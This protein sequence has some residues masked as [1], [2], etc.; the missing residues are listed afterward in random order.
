MGCA[1]GSEWKAEQLFMKELLGFNPVLWRKH[2]T[3]PES[4]ES[5][6]V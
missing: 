2:L 5:M 1:K 6:E 4:R 3:A